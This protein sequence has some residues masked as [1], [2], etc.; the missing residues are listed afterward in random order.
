[1]AKTGK[2]FVS[3][4]IPLYYQLENVLREKIT[5]GAYGPGEQ[6]PTETD[7]IEQFKVSRI[8]VRQALAALADE[9]LIERRQG[10]GTFVTQRKT[11]KRKFDGFIHLT[12]SLDELI[13]MGLDMPVKLLEINRIVADKHE[14]ALLQVKTGTTV[15]MLKR[16]RLYEGTPYSLI[17][18]YLPAEI[19]EKLTNSELNSGTI[20]QSIEN[21]LGYNLHE[22]RQQI[23]AELADPYVA[24]LLDVRVGS[25]LLSI[26][27]TVYDDAGKP[28]EF[29]HSLYRSDKYGFS[30]YFKR[31]SE[32]RKRDET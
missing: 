1:M 5:S 29:V 27:R 11:R 6:L 15:F 7:F 3:S 17:V 25:A 10:S 26:E 21:K 18:N 9:G 4:R 19:G 16:L 20:L 14:A 32:S 8:T 24:E 23:K 28:V 22:A 13:E 31:E 30:V 2:G 12:G